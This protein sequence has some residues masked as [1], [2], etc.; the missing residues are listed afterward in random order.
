MSVFSLFGGGGGGRLG[1]SE[2]GLLMVGGGGGGHDWVLQGSVLALG[3][4]HF[5]PPCRDCLEIVLVNVLVPPPQAL[6]HLPALPPATF[7]ALH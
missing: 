2:G 5:L 3:P 6:V 7:Q 1:G 4:A